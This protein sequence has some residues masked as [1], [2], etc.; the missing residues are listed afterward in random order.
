MNGSVDSI[1]FPAMYDIFFNI[2]GEGITIKSVTS[3]GV[4]DAAGEFHCRLDVDSYRFIAQGF[5]LGLYVAVREEGVVILSDPD[6]LREDDDLV[7]GLD[8]PLY[9]HANASA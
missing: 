4:P 3:G 7:F 2:S 1:G 5:D 6:D 8:G 9:D